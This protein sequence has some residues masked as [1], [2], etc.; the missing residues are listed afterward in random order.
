MP[1]EKVMTHTFSGK[2]AIDVRDSEQEGLQGRRNVVV[3][4]DEP[5]R[6]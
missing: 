6:K 2:I 1:Q 3:A 4:R 5:V